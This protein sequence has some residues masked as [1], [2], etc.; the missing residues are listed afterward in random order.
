MSG[1]C[2]VHCLLFI[3]EELNF[4]IGVY[5]LPT[6]KRLIWNLNRGL[7]SSQEKRLIWNRGL[8]FSHEKKIDL[9]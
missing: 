4:G 2:T 5:N 6:K 7:Q 3:I 1:G 9:E 8:Q